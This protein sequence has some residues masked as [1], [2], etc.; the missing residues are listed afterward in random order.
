M[1]KKTYKGKP[2]ERIVDEKTLKPIATFDKEGKC[3]VTVIKNQ[4]RLD[5]HFKEG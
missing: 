1:A 2:N 5:K 4:K 3:D